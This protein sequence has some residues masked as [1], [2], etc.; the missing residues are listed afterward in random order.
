MNLSKIFLV[1]PIFM[2]KKFK[3][4]KTIKDHFLLYTVYKV[5]YNFLMNFLTKSHFLKSLKTNK[6]FNASISCSS[7]YN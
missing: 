1:L 2:K 7:F 6:T 4:K 5:V 3:G